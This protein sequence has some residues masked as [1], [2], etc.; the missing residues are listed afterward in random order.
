MSNAPVGAWPSKYFP[1]H[2]QY[3]QGL[4]LRHLE[5]LPKALGRLQF[6]Q[7]VQLRYV[8]SVVRST[9]RFSLHGHWLHI[10]QT[11]VF[12]RIVFGIYLSYLYE[13]LHNPCPSPHLE[14][15]I[16]SAA[17]ELNNVQISYAKKYSWQDL[18]KFTSDRTLLLKFILIFYS[19][20]NMI[21]MPHKVV[22]Y[23]YM[24]KI[25]ENKNSMI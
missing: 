11:I 19:N 1:I 10:W 7:K 5:F 8:I 2:E 25:N 14:K 15:E 21:N 20:I 9:L 17:Y 12:R 3:S 16:E 4:A 18:S 22:L 24:W 13:R 6:R 23:I